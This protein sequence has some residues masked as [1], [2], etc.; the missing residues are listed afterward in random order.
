MDPTIEWART[1]NILRDPMDPYGSL[2][3]PMDA[4]DEYA[5]NDSERVEYTCNRKYMGLGFIVLHWIVPNR[6]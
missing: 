5:C 2:K 4:H 1:C 3:I 6:N